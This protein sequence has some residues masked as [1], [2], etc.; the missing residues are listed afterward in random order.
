MSAPPGSRRE[1]AAG[2]FSSCPAFGA[3]TLRRMSARKRPNERNEGS[4]DSAT[5]YA[6]EYR[7]GSKG[8]G[9]VARDGTAFI[10]IPLSCKRM[11]RSVTQCAMRRLG[12]A[13]DV[14]NALCFSFVFAAVVLITPTRHA[15]RK[16]AAIF[17]NDEH[18]P[19]RI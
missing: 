19:E 1:T 6:Q 12:F 7:M 3:R 17:V 5:S 15:P 9:G 13:R 8:I 2:S 10:I 11:T 4:P 16:P 14:L 18:M